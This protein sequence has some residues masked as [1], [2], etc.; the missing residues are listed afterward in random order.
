[1]SDRAGRWWPKDPLTLG[2]AVVGLIVSVGSC[3]AAAVAG[4]T[5]NNIQA[6]VRDLNARVD[7]NLV[8]LKSDYVKGTKPSIVN[9][10]LELSNVGPGVASHVTF[11]IASAQGYP[12]QR[13]IGVNDSL[14]G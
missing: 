1:M 6:E 10:V 14:D 7:L 9:F 4:D 5:S 2:I 3:H 8:T 12:S 13:A 11:G